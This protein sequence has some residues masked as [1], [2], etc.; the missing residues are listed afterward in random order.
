[1]KLIPL[2]KGYFAK[3]DDEDFDRL[4]K[5]KWGVSIARRGTANPYATRGMKIGG[6]S[7]TIFM[8]HEVLNFEVKSK[9]DHRDGDSLNNQKYNLR[10]ANSIEN[11]RNR[12]I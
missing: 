9:L 5:F 1:M 12:K 3:V 8:H 2:N 11:G 6:V 7:K 4:S 10:P